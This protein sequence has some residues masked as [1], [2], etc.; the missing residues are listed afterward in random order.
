MNGNEDDAEKRGM[1]WEEANSCMF[2]AL[3]VSVHRRS[4]FTK[5]RFYTIRIHPRAPLALPLGTASRRVYYRVHVDVCR[6]WPTMRGNLKPGTAKP[7][8]VQDIGAAAYHIY[9]LWWCWQVRRHISALRCTFVQSTHVLD[10]HVFICWLI[11]PFRSHFKGWLEQFR[12]GNMTPVCVL[13]LCFAVNFTS[14]GFVTPSR[15]KGHVN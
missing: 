3:F 5:T 4:C 7:V 10:S 1:L 15:T 13:S 6:C 9:T 14:V 11:W 8:S 2:A 12:K